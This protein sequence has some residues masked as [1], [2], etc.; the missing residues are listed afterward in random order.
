MKRKLSIL[1]SVLIVVGLLLT[2]CQAQETATVVT[3]PEVVAPATTAPEQAP[4]RTP[5][6]RQQ[7]P[8]WL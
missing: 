3:T 2:A 6:D 4:M 8:S 5:L 1:F 7:N